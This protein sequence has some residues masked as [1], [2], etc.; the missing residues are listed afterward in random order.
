MFENVTPDD[1]MS[2]VHFYNQRTIFDETPYNEDKDR[3]LEY[4]PVNGSGFEW[5]FTFNVDCPLRYRNWNSGE[6]VNLQDI[7][8][9]SART[10]RLKFDI[11]SLHD[12]GPIYFMLPDIVVDIDSM[13]ETDLQDQIY[14]LTVTKSGNK[15]FLVVYPLFK[16]GYMKN[17]VRPNSLPILN[18]KLSLHIIETIIEKEKELVEKFVFNLKDNY[19]KYKMGKTNIRYEDEENEVVYV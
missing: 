14:N 1:F 11:E 18:R 16:I 10:V 15:K 3:L 5:Y 2:V 17:R 4:Y 7:L 12:F 9:F 6:L 8:E 19:Q 13:Y